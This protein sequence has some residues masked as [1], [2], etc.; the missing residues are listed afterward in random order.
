MRV[1]YHPFQKIPND[2]RLL[3]FALLCVVT[4]SLMVVMGVKKVEPQGIISLELAGNV[5]TA[6]QIVESW[7]MSSQRNALFNV[8]LD[9]LFIIAYSNTIGLACVWA[10]ETISTGAQVVS[11]V[12][13]AL[14]W[15]QWLA[16]LL[17]VVENIA[18]LSMLRISVTQPFPAVALWCAVPKFELVVAGLLYTVSAVCI[19]VA[20]R[21][22]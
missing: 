2:K 4:I 18:L 9:F 20:C 10:A 8:R 14:V 3:V 13:I 15:G 5:P 21:V 16:A 11:A 22:L 19:E 6:Q 12:G 7:D 1:A 17:D